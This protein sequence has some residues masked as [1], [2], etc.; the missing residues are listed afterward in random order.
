ME[1]II[2]LWTTGLNLLLDVF[3]KLAVIL[4]SIPF[5]SQHTELFVVPYLLM[6]ALSLSLYIALW[7]FP[8]I[9]ALIFFWLGLKKCS[10]SVFGCVKNFKI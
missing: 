10:T 2:H 6:G 9:I 4:D 5:V 8:P 1:L 7:F 3:T